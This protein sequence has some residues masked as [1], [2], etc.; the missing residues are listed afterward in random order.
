[1][2]TVDEGMTFDK[3]FKH[4]HLENPIFLQGMFWG[5]FFLITLV[6]TIY[7]KFEEAAEKEAAER[8]EHAKT[9]KPSPS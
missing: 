6:A 9:S 1:M 3:F 4:C 2:S 7:Y 8:A 5:I